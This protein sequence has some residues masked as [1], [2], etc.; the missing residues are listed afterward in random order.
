MVDG[1]EV[2]S[3][4]HF[5]SAWVSNRLK[6]LRFLGILRALCVSTGQMEMCAIFLVN[7]TDPKIYSSSI[8][9]Y[10]PCSLSQA[11]AIMLR[12]STYINITSLNNIA[13]TYYFLMFVVAFPS[14]AHLVPKG[15]VF[16]N[17][18]VSNLST[19]KNVRHTLP[20]T[21]KV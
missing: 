11:Q 6:K 2:N 16:S 14:L 4:M 10:N 12:S 20:G 17:N 13:M 19:L 5:D 7:P 9:T 3:C 21:G 18:L 15:L 1:D 8:Q